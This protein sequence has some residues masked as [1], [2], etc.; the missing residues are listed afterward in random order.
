MPAVFGVLLLGVHP[1][2]LAVAGLIAGHAS[3]AQTTGT[4]AYPSKPIR[5][6][7]SLAAGGGNDT[8]ARIIAQ[9]LTDAW[10]QQVV[11]E[12]RPGAGGTIAAESAVRA[13]ADGY[14]LL[15]AS[16]S[17]AITPSIYKLAYDPARELAAV[18]LVVLSPSVLVVH[19]S[20]PV[21]SVKELIA[22]ARARPDELLWSSSGNGSSQHLAMEL[23][24]RMA[25]VKLMHVAYKGTAP[26]MTDL[27]G[28]R[29]SV[30]AAS[31]IS[32]MPHVKA[33][34]LRALAVISAHRSPAVPELPT[35]AEAGVP[36]YAVDTWYG[37]FAPAATPKDI[38]AKLY[39]E[40]GRT[41]KQPEMKD[42]LASIGLEPV[43]TPPGEFAVYV[44]AE[45]DKWGRVV[46]EAGV[47]IN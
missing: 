13:P 3:W 20:L 21:H 11:V 42:K 33:G 7:S 15:M 9:K 37:L 43:G 14:T 34:K 30:S 41:L 27:I 24:N 35:V 31:A 4:A 10:G 38:V 23:F 12:N 36:G 28:G 2:A 39:E 44:R 46:R 5:M 6:I 40:I 18:T 17:L 19:P 16:M 29:V 45:I 47:H 22:F 25:G 26:S 32:T 8:S 1:F